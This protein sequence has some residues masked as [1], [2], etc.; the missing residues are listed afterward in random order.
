MRL[1]PLSLKILLNLFLVY[2]SWGSTYIGFEFTLE[3][4]GP[5]LACGS[6][7]F[8]AGLLLC[9]AIACTG[10]WQRP[11]RADWRHACW[12]CR[13]HG[14]DGQR[15]SGQ[16]AGVHFFRRGR[17]GYR[18]HAYFHAGGSLAVRRRAAPFGHAVAGTGRWPVRPGS[19][20]LQPGRF[21]RGAEQPGRH[22]L[23]FRGYLGLGDRFSADPAF[24]PVHPAF[25]LAVLRPAAAYRRPGKPAAGLW[26]AARRP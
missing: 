16:G 5:F 10:R 19:A 26:P 3:V 24:S 11:S 18:F 7:M 2:I 1:S 8:L 25:G 4:L 23:G 6:R 21:R 20:G 17:R 22:F 13:V 12:P 9:A 15:L 14:L